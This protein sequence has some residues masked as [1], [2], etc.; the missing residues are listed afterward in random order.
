MERKIESHRPTEI[1][2]S[3]GEYIDFI[4]LPHLRGFFRPSVHHE[5]PKRKITGEILRP[6]E[7][8]DRCQRFSRLE[9]ATSLLDDFE[10]KDYQG[11]RELT[12]G[13]SPPLARV[14]AEDMIKQLHLQDYLSL[15][16]E[17]DE[18]V[19]RNPRRLVLDEN[20]EK[21]RKRITGYVWDAEKTDE[22]KGTNPARKPQRKLRAYIED[23]TN[24]RNELIEKNIGLVRVYAIEYFLM[25]NKEISVDEFLQIG[26]GFLREEN[27]RGNR[28]LLRAIETFDWRRG[29]AFSTLASWYINVTMQDALRAHEASKTAQLP[30]IERAPTSEARN[31]I[32][33]VEF[34]EDIDMLRKYINY[35][36]LTTDEMKALELLVLEGRTTGDAAHKMRRH[37]SQPSPQ[38][39]NRLRN[40]GIEKLR[41]VAKDLPAAR[42]RAHVI[43][44][45]MHEDI[46]KDMPYI[47]R[48]RKRFGF[49]ETDLAVL[50]PIY[51]KGESLPQIAK[52]EDLAYSTIHK[53]H[54]RALAKIKRESRIRNR[55]VERASHLSVETVRKYI[56]LL[57]ENQQHVLEA[58]YG[59]L[60]PTKDIAEGEFVSLEPI[61]MRRKE[62]LATLVALTKQETNEQEL[63]MKTPLTVTEVQD[64]L[65]SNLASLL[66]DLQRQILES[67]IIQGQEQRAI[68][69][70]L[71]LKRSTYKT[72]FN[73]AQKLVLDLMR[74]PE[75]RRIEEQIVGIKLKSVLNTLRTLTEDQV[76]RIIEATDSSERDKAI[77]KASVVTNKSIYT[78]AEE[79]NIKKS[80]VQNIREAVARNLARIAVKNNYQQL[81][82]RF[83]DL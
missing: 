19:E 60:Q 51:M 1:P 32:I 81:L 40:S 25:A 28:G 5:I 50:R 75:K 14:I 24:S 64:F 26:Y 55:T 31:P 4:D 58:Y 38:D 10:R 82:Q 48:M 56:N 36:Y 59:E 37:R 42:I 44:T 66:S 76:N 18:L 33:I 71:A 65:Q 16:V 6:R 41:A 46:I 57:P 70:G 9:L 67:A 11:T 22:L 2:Q 61:Q 74:N 20:E 12:A 62:A 15:E 27:A 8:T 80:Q 47:L 29:N 78:L 17:E 73:S 49:T 52:D 63:K 35:A 7:I 53:R 79:F 69:E 45:L 39:L 21:R 68:L 13:T 30:D 34:K 3:E 23:A 77:F 72:S 54:E 83:R 43:D